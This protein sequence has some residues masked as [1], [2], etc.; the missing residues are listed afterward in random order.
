[1]TARWTGYVRFDFTDPHGRWT[2][3]VFRR[4]AGPAVIVIHEMPGLHP[5]VTRFADR[6]AAAGMTVFCPSLFG[7]PGTVTA[8]YA[9]GTMLEAI[10]IRRDP[11]LIDRPFEPHRRL[12]AGARRLRTRR[13]RRQRRGRGRDVF[14]RRIRPGDDDRGGH[15]RPGPLPALAAVDGPVEAPGARSGRLAGRDRLRQATVRAGGFVDD[16]TAIPQRSLRSSPGSLH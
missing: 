2:R 13:V 6:V 8:G 9:L 4:G 10:C 7:R 1:M 3:P 15:G 16:R 5:L 14:H 12:A 11:C